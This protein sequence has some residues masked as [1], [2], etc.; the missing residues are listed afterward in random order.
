MRYAVPVNAANEVSA[1][2]QAGAD[3]L[4]CG[5]QDRW[6][7]ERYGNHDSASRRQG[8][9]NFATLEE[10][11]RCVDASRVHGLPIWLALNSRYTEPQ[12]DHLVTLCQRFEDMG[13]TGVI[14]SDLG[15]LWRLHGATSFRRCLSLLA[16]A[17]NGATLKA[18][19]Q[20][21]ITR[22]VLPRFVGPDEADALLRAVPGMEAEVMAFF[23]KCPWVD[24][25]CRHR[26]GVTYAPRVVA[27]GED[28]APPLYTFDTAYQ[29]HVCLGRACTYLEPYPC[30]A[31]FLP[32]FER[33]GVGL[34]KL[35]GRGRPLDERLRAVRFL[36]AVQAL[37]SDGERARLYEQTFSQ[38]C[39]CYYGRAIQSRRAI[40][41]VE[42]PSIGC[43]GTVL[44]SQ[45]DYAAYQVGRAHLFEGTGLVGE[46]SSNNAEVTLL[47]PPLA[48]QGLSEL[49]EALAS[50]PEQGMAGLHLCVNDL[51]TYLTLERLRRQQGCAFT[52]APGTLLLRVDDPDEVRHCLSARENPPKAVWGPNGEPRVLTYRTPPEELVTHWN[53]PSFMEPSA[54]AA[55]AALLD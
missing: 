12:L 41:P 11:A 44:G 9:A 19:R 40:E 31:C 43:A 47:V 14:L 25:Y 4:Y 10:L 55:L 28:D 23:D 15:L 52:L 39:A 26:H 42:R 16:V 29:T 32:R 27:E 37:P 38:S 30:A 24:G 33:V 34:A 17:Q 49:H 53:R 45:T 51:G 54:Q 1:L 7:I 8:R 20:L 46:T 2:A 50:L 18:Y 3:E 6:W 35:G 22:A 36:R 21:G 13:G 48:D 5:Y